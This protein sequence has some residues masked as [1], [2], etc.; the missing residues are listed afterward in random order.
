MSRPPPSHSPAAVHLPLLTLRECRARSIEAKQKT[1]GRNDETPTSTATVPTFVSFIAVLVSCD[2]PRTIQRRDG[3]EVS[4]TTCLVSDSSE[5]YMQVKF[6]NGGLTGSGSGSG[7]GSVSRTL[8]LLRVGQVA[9]FHLFELTRFRELVTFTAKA[10]SQMHIVLTHDAR[11]FEHN[12]DVMAVA[13]GSRSASPS[14]YSSLPFSA[15]FLNWPEILTHARAVWS[16]QQIQGFGALTTH[17]QQHRP[18]TR[19]IPHSRPP[20][21]T[22]AAQQQQH[23]P[24]AH[25]SRPVVSLDSLVPGMTTSIVARLRSCHIVPRTTNPHATNAPNDLESGADSTLVAVLSESACSR[26]PLDPPDGVDVVSD[27]RLLGDTFVSL[28][29]HSSQYLSPSWI[30]FWQSMIGETLRFDEVRAVWNPRAETITLVET[31]HTGQ[32]DDRW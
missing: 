1:N 15:R 24:A 9:L 13:T 20:P 25:S 12:G 19:A 4:L 6:W 26:A 2:E 23:H 10:R 28:S 27:D 17:Q 32:S 31:T 18:P 11:L 29:M 22:A 3:S 8:P 14:A 21:I 5:R 30:Q 7:V 16:G